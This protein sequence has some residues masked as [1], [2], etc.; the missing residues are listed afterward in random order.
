MFKKTI[1]K[2]ALQAQIVT[3][4]VI[5]NIFFV[6]VLSVLLANIIVRSCCFHLKHNCINH[7][8][9]IKGPPVLVVVFFCRGVSSLYLNRLYAAFKFH[10][11]LFI[12]AIN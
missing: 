4:G 1:S 6:S 9:V 2:V 12:I 5:I 11:H 8:L 3:I 10:I 7:I